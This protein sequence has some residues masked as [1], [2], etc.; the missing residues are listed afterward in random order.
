MILPWFD[1]FILEP[2]GPPQR[3]RVILRWWMSG[4]R[5]Y[6]FGPGQLSDGSLRLMALVTLLLQPPDRLPGMLIIDEPELGLHP[7]AEQVLAG[8]LKSVAHHTQVLVA[9]QSATFLDHFSPENVVVV[10]NQ[11]GESTY[12]RLDA[13]Q[14][15]SWLKRYTLGEIWSKNLIGGRP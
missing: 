3:Q 15:S 6:E 14:L 13:D 1:E 4:H 10:E 5:D 7:A 2:E 12:T 9:T 11:D 8:L